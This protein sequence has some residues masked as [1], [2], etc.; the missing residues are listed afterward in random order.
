MEN[1]IEHT[2]VIVIP[3]INI[4]K[5]QALLDGF[6]TNIEETWSMLYKRMAVM[7]GWQSWMSSVVKTVD[8]YQMLPEWSNCRFREGCSDE[9]SLLKIVT[10]MTNEQWVKFDEQ[11]GVMPYRWYPDHDKVSGEDGHDINGLVV[12]VH[13][14]PDIKHDEGLD[15]DGVRIFHRD[16]SIGTLELVNEYAPIDYFLWDRGCPMNFCKRVDEWTSYDPHPV[17][18]LSFSRLTKSAGMVQPVKF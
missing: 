15:E 7:R 17:S 18:S 8:F 4:D 9:S 10:I 1:I 6:E 13:W 16:Q 14:Y 11:L 3:H 12:Y 5:Q 2:I